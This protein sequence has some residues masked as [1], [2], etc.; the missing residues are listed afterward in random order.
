MLAAAAAK[1][2]AARYRG[3]DGR[4]WLG[5]GLRR[6]EDVWAVSFGHLS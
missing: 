5:R 6:H 4:E 3:R 2:A 1:A